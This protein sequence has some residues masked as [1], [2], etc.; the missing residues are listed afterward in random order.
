MY[1]VQYNIF[2]PIMT[3]NVV[4]AGSSLTERKYDQNIF[5]N[6]QTGQGRTQDR[7]GRPLRLNMD[8]SVFY[9]LV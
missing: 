5:K 8:P 3:K 1:K 7:T 4:L 2:K 9:S 6:T